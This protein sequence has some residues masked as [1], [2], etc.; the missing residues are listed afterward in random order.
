MSATPIAAITGLGTAVPARVVTNA[1][2]AAYLDTSD[3][4]I[5][6]R[7][8]LPGEDDAADYLKE[9]CYGATD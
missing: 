9:Y 2:F 5:S 3:Q 4:W 8:F 6:E 7:T 1:D